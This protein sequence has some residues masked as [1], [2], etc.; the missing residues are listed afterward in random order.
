M[1]DPAHQD[2]LFGVRRLRNRYRR[3]VL[4][5]YLVQASFYGLLVTA[6]ALVLFPAIEPWRLALAVLLAVAVTAAALG[7]KHRRSFTHL[8]KDFDNHAGWKDRFSS[9][10]DLM[11]SSDPV[12]RHLVQQTA[13]AA[14]DLS[15]EKLYPYRVPREGWLMPLPVLL[16]AA[17]LFLPGMLHGEAPPNPELESTLASQI[18]RVED[19]LSRER[20]E[21]PTENRKEVLQQLEELKKELSRDPID[22]K[23]AM[24]EI[25]KLMEEIRKSQEENEEQKAKLEEMLRNFKSNDRNQKLSEAMQAGQYADAANRIDELLE[26]MR[27]ELRKLKKKGADP[28]KLKELEEQIRELENLKAQLLKL[29]NVRYDLQFAGEILDVLSECE[30]ELGGLPDDDIEDVWFVRLGKCQGQCESDKILRL[31]QKLISPESKKA[32]K[33]TMAKFLADDPTRSDGSHEEV[34]VRVREGKGRSSFTQTQVS[35]DGSQSQLEAKEV[36]AAERRAA[37]DTIERQDVPASYREYIRKYFEG[38]QPEA[39]SQQK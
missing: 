15:T 17:V 30:G 34:K 21:V 32:G 16:V 23:D 39:T 29:L 18:Q 12:A 19:L 33:A 11:Q 22:K 9:S 3:V 7:W 6:A 25:S 24:A 8:A 36:L 14:R 1:S 31:H 4:L 28:E 37:Q 27:D 26:E 5:R 13:T 10:V 35:N 2:L 38:I 20:E